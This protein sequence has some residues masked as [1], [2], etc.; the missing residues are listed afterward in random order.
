MAAARSTL[1]L[2]PRSSLRGASTFGASQLH[3]SAR[4]A[5]PAGKGDQGG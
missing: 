1:R 2:L 4:L 3:T 5:R